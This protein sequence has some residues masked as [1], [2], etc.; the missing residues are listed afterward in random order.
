MGFFFVMYGT[1]SSLKEQNYKLLPMPAVKKIVILIL[2]KTNYA[3]TI[4]A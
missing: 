4:P 1:S 3:Q 2:L